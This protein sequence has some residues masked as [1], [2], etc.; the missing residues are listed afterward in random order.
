MSFSHSLPEAQEPPT[1]QETPVRIVGIGASAGGLEALERFF[2]FVPSATGASYVIVQ[3]LSPEHKSFMAELLARHTTMHISVVTNELK[4]EPN[5][6]Y[7]IPPRKF[8]TVRDGVLRLNDYATKRDSLQPIDDFFESLAGDQGSNAIAVILSG[9]GTDGTRG[10]RA[11]HDVGGLVM[12]QSEASAAFEGM[13]RSAIS[14]GLV[15]H[16]QTPEELARKLLGVLVPLDTN[17]VEEILPALYQLLKDSHGIDYSGYKRAGVVR[18][19]E[20]R[21]KLKS[22]S[23]PVGYREYIESHPEE[24]SALQKDLLIGVT[25]FFRDPEAFAALYEKVI[26]SIV[27]HKLKS[28]EKEIRVWV[29]ACSTGEEAYTVAMLFQQ[30]LREH[31]HDLDLRIFATDLD[32]E[33][34]QYAS[35]GNY[36]LQLEEDVP[37]E[38]VE[39]YFIRHGDAY[40]VT[41]ELRKPIVFAPH[42]I[43]QDPPFLNMDLVTCRNMMIYF[44]ADVQKKV[45]SLFHFSL[46]KYGYLFLGPS[47]SVGKLTH[48]FEHYDK[49]WNIFRHAITSPTMQVKTQTTLDMLGSAGT[50][51][52]QG[53][54][55]LTHTPVPQPLRKL[56]DV[57]SMLIEEYMPPSILLDGNNDVVHT[58]GDLSKY[59]VIPRGKLSFNIHKMVSTPLSVFIGTA[60]HKVRKNDQP[61][62]YL[63]VAIPGVEGQQITVNITVKKFKAARNN[64][65]LLLLFEESDNETIPTLIPTPYNPD[66][67]VKL[68]IEELERELSYARES[69][70]ATI[71]ELET[72]NEELQATNEEMIA[73]NEEMQSTNEELQSVNE[74]LFTVNAEHQRK[75]LELTELNNDMD[76]FLI[77]TKIGTIFLDHDLCIRRFTPAVTK[78]IHLLEIDIGRPLS[79]M[80]HR[81]KY[82]R[83]LEDAREVLTHVVPTERE[84]QTVEGDWYSVGILPYRTVENQ[85]KGVVVTFVDITDLKRANQE[86]QKLSYAIQ[87][88]PSTML[89]ADVEG[90]VEYV[91]ATYSRLTGYELNEVLGRSMRDL[92]EVSGAGGVEFEEIWRTIRQGRR[93]SG[94]LESLRKDGLSRWEQVSFLPL[95]NE[96]GE[97]IHFLKTSQDITEHKRTEEL[98]RKSEM[99]SAVGQLAAGIAHEIRNPLTALKGF[100]QLL[101][102]EGDKN[103]TYVKIMSSEFVRIEQII[104]ELLMLSKPHE[105][106]F[107]RANLAVI[108]NDVLM[109]LETQA[110]MN[111]IHINSELANPLP[112]VE[113]VENQIKQVLINMLKNAMEAMPSGG[114]ITFTV[115]RHDQNHVLIRIQDQGIGI[116]EEQLRRIG[117][118][119]YTTKDK[120]TGLGIMVSKKIIEDH[121]GRFQISSIVGVGTTIDII[122]PTLP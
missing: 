88:S 8:M 100:L 5:Q 109:L 76:N 12:V 29:S 111:Q 66:D 83:L 25:H 35:L 41:K 49:R 99:H 51:V 48:L 77:S 71:E 42:N 57:Y 84:I 28:G 44:E 34:V 1:R 16:V 38:Y 50:T 19:V 118:P 23:S 13:P 122:L 21:M 89:I 27:E 62:R 46:N 60:L 87:Q 56:D 104:N 121:G 79:H 75:I 93:W 110:I 112:F 65:L 73:A 116:P 114:E 78:V 91:N 4:I 69:L 47:E 32:Q 113:C 37:K 119:F 26:P 81:L 96:T 52:R 2:D 68:R 85:I 72:S 92:H 70:Q 74:E 3:H 101:H 115:R 64:D 67:N 107:H 103:E 94:E 18:R 59:L 108:L 40:Q 36:P 11:I 45:L 54:R 95:Q 31:G 33:S 14:T 22:I 82:D 61:V 106:N 105:L 30:Y 17:D 80:S 7:L 10:I 86:L 39:R 97:T 90:K 55:E 9:T 120:G 58:F 102:V 63:N 117:E 43:I 20:R 24:I 53:N 15:H 6:I 98:L